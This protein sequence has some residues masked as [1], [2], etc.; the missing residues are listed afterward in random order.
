MIV[1]KKTLNM[2]DKNFLLAGMHLTV[3]KDQDNARNQGGGDFRLKLEDEKMKG[4]T[5]Y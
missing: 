2:E 1:I 3:L 4:I 5:T